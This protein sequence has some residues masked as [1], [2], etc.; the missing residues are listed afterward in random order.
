MESMEGDLPKMDEVKIEDV[1]IEQ[2]KIEE[3][4]EG[5]TDVKPEPST[6]PPARIGKLQFKDIPLD[7]KRMI[8]GYVRGA[9]SYICYIVVLYPH[10]S[11][12]VSLTTALQIVKAL[13]TYYAFKR[14]ISHLSLGLFVR[15]YV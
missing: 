9:F 2:L 1:N 8:L 10:L 11:I 13:Q 7:L 4:K 14:F 5:G 12:F 6:A 15:I 3:I